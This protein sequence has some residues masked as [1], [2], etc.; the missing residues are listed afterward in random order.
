MRTG[1][2]KRKNRSAARR[3]GLGRKMRRKS[4]K[5]EAWAKRRK[6]ERRR[7][8]KEDSR[9]ERRKTETARGIFGRTSQK[10]EMGLGPIDL[11]TQFRPKPN[12]INEKDTQGPN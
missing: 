11:A 8:K 1:H 6:K 7:R 2:E 10:S 12:D 5:K 4:Q 3:T 9:R